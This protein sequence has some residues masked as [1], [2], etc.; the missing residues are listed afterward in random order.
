M[1]VLLLLL[2]LRYETRVAV[3]MQENNSPAYH[4]VNINHKA[5]ANARAR[6]LRIEIKLPLKDGKFPAEA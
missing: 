5:T 6:Y 3:H 4:M 1:F 2:S